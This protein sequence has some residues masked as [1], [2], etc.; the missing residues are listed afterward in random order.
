MMGSNLGEQEANVDDF[1]SRRWAQCS[2][3]RDMENSSAQ[4]KR[5]RAVAA[6]VQLR[7][8]GRKLERPP[9]HA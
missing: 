2:C 3:V 4:R 8:L 9:G 5:G 6:A 1:R 7:S